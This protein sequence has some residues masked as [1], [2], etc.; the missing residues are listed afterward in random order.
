[1][2]LEK[3]LPASNHGLQLCVWP[4]QLPWLGAVA[5]EHAQ[6]FERAT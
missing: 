1:M 3:I 5:D 6:L 2:L 4:W